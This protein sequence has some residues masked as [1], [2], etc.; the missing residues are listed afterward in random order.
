MEEAKSDDDETHEDEL[1]IIHSLPPLPEKEEDKEG[2]SSQVRDTMNQLGDVAKMKL[3]V[4]ITMLV[5]DDMSGDVRVE[6]NLQESELDTSL[7][8]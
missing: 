5:H 2:Q 1:Q 3:D 7:E 8:N 4:T 6:V